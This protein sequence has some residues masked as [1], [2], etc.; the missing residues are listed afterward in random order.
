MFK[1]MKSIVSVSLA[2]LIVLQTNVVIASANDFAHVH[3]PQQ[4]IATTC[5]M[6]PPTS[7]VFVGTTIINMQ[8]NHLNG[9]SIFGPG[10]SL[11]SNQSV[12]PAQVSNRAIGVF[13][14]TNRDAYIGLVQVTGTRVVEVHR[15]AVPSTGGVNTMTFSFTTPTLT[16]AAGSVRGYVRNRT[17][18]IL[19]NSQI[20]FVRS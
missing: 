1:K 6:P 18:H 10:P 9:T 19:S 16:Q 3:T 2:L 12:A 4:E 5:L 13:Y 11:H 17:P 15:R 8:I 14:R 20:Q 7:R